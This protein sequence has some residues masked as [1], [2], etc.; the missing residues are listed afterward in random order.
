M[1]STGI[2]STPVA[3]VTRPNAILLASGFRSADRGCSLAR[4]LEVARD[5]HKVVPITEARSMPEEEVARRTEWAL[6]AKRDTPEAGE[7][8][9]LGA[10]DGRAL[11]EALE[12]AESYLY[13]A[14]AA[15][16]EYLP[17]IPLPVEEAMSQVRSAI[18]SRETWRVLSAVSRLTAILEEFFPPDGSDG[19]K[20]AQASLG[21]A[22][23]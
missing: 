3:D 15:C 23:K 16:L 6:I 13:T 18:E 20:A 9:A 7:R 11:E 19:P 12:A 21:S 17:R 22:K 8:Q 14:K 10:R 4:V 1:D 2:A 5:K